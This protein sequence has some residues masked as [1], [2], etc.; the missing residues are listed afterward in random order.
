MSEP[1]SASE[2]AIIDAL[3]HWVEAAVIGL[4]LCPFAKPV[5]RKG[6]VRYVVSGARTEDQLLADLRTELQ[7]LHATP[8]DVTDNTLLIHPQV[9]ED[10]FAYQTFLPRA[11]AAVRKAGLQ[12]EIQIA[13]FHPQYQFAECEPDALSNY[14]NRAPYPTLHLLREA[15]IEQAVQAFPAAESIYERNMATLQEL[16]PAGWEALQIKPAPVSGKTSAG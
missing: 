13:S 8:A 9:L 3:R 12:G 16:G 4:N 5:Q 11:E 15:S 7:H 6:L 10:F 2:A 1:P 14:T